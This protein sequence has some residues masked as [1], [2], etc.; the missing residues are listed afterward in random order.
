MGWYQF[1]Q[2]VW[3]EIFTSGRVEYPVPPEFTHRTEV[4]KL[5][6]RDH[7]LIA[8]D[9]LRSTRERDQY[10]AGI[11]EEYLRTHLRY[12]KIVCEKIKDRYPEY[13][14]YLSRNR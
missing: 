12:A 6:Q 1:R 11:Y 2:T 9:V 7:I 13:G 8:I 5:N 10:D 3:D 14:E 4:K